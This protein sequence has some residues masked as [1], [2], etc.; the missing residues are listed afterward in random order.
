MTGNLLFS[1]GTD[2]IRLLGCNDLAP[3]KGFTLALGNLQNE[4]Q[5]EVTAPQH[6]QT[7]LTL[8]TTHGFLI[9]SNDSDVIQIGGNTD[10]PPITKVYINVMMGSHRLL[11]LHE[12]TS[13]SEAATKTYV[14][15][16]TTHHCL[17]R[18]E[19][20]SEWRKI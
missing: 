10:G 16:Q 12:P 9:Q 4:M 14:L 20:H 2:L 5:F 18:G 19:G 11:N 6:T 17:G 13:G 1:A 8:K 7:P 15:T 3:G